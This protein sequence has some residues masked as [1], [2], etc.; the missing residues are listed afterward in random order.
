M[1]LLRPGRLSD[2]CAHAETCLQRSQC[3]LRSSCQSSC[4]LRPGSV[5]W[6]IR[7][8]FANA[9]ILEVLAML[10]GPRLSHV[11]EVKGLTRLSSFLDWLNPFNYLMGGL[12]VFPLWDQEVVCSAA[13]LG[14]FSPPGGQTCGQYMSSF[15]S[16][17]AG[18]LV[19]PVSEAASAETTA[20]LIR[21]TR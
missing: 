10:V 16:R 13:E 5:Q 17:T 4:H 6:C 2:I 12:L 15:L 14:R 1:S 19:D 7:A 18:Y 11:P 20:C 9:G 21:V 3:H 8:I